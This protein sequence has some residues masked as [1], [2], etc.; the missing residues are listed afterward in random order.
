VLQQAS[1][2]VLRAGL[3][4]ARRPQESSSVA[5]SSQRLVTG[6]SPAPSRASPTRHLHAAVP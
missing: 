2:L 3:A 6:M 5:V 1:S 4:A